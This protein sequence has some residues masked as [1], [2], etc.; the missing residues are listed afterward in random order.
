MNRNNLNTEDNFWPCVSD[1][2]LAFFVIALA[3]YATSNSEKGRGDEYISSLARE[4]AIALVEHLHKVHEGDVE[5][6]PDEVK[7]EQDTLDSPGLALHLYKLT[8]KPAL[9]KLYFNQAAN[10]EKV[11]PYIPEEGKKYHLRK[12]ARLLYC[13]TFPER[14]MNVEESDPRYHRLLREVRDCLQRKAGGLESKTKEELMDDLRNSV[15]RSE[16]AALEARVK[17]LTKQIAELQEKLR[18]ATQGN[19]L[20]E[21]LQKEL[22]E[23]KKQLED[24]R[25]QLE[26]ARSQITGLEADKTNLSHEVQQ[27]I[28]E[29]NRDNR[30]SVMGEIEQL[31]KQD[32]YRALGAGI[33]LLKEEGVIRIPES[34][35]G[36]DANA[37]EPKKESLGNIKL[38]SDLLN[39]IGTL[40][41]RGELLIDNISIECHA[42]PSGSGVIGAAVI[43]V[44]NSSRKPE[45]IKL[46]N[47]W[48]SMMRAL[49]IWNQLEKERNPE[50]KLAGYK[51]KG[52]LGLFSTSGFGARVPVKK[53]VGEG[54]KE[55]LSRCRRMDIRI[56]CSP[57]KML[58]VQK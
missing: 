25:R 46:D 35:V 37:R 7:K 55:W 57:E 26:E 33:L 48:L 23:L 10:E 51:N 12:A 18:Q 8:E 3:L 38:I 56:N 4:E 32:K 15:P 29:I 30:K 52:G 28:D 19:A 39:D 53:E 31:L 34:V 22:E 49:S 42:D 21:S 36:F 41:K 1:M 44:G 50:N 11:L 13:L 17:Q 40:V 16:L 2:F 24:A 6:L 27:L 20:L 47:D 43:K 9:V 14:E 54:E 58:P 5:A 45:N